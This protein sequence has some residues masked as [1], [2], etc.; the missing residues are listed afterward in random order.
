MPA[1]YS[2]KWAVLLVI[3]YLLTGCSGV[4]Q[5]SEAAK[6]ILTISSPSD[7]TVVHVASVQVTGS[8]SAGAEIVQDISMA[9]DQRTSADSSGRWVLTVDLEEGENVL[10]FRIGSDDSTTK[11]IRVTYSPAAETPKPTRSESASAAASPTATSAPEPIETPAPTPKPTATPKPTPVAITFGSGDFIVGEDVKPGTYRTRETA[12]MC[13]WERLKG[14]GG[15]LDEIIANGTGSG[16]FVVTIGKNDVGFS[17][18]GCGEW[19]SDLSAVIDPNGPIDEDGTYIVGKDMKPGTW[20]SDGGAGF[21]CYAARLSGFGGTLN[22]IIT[23]DVSTDGGLVMTI[24]STDKGF[25]TSGCGTW[26]K[27]K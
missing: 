11:T 19:S 21:G 9:P 18:S 15:T 10:K 13:Y 3:A 20:R 24:K 5:S 12:D 4:A 2:P 1:L 8:A 7:G 25:E 27:I 6:G 14:W 16:Y 17:T 23:N 26:K 22:N